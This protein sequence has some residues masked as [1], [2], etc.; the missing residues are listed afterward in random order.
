MTKKQLIIRTAIELFSEKGVESTSVQQITDKSGIS[1]G[2]FY[3]IF[4]S[5]EELILAIID[6]F[7]VDF[8]TKVDQAVRAKHSPDDKL[9]S[10]YLTSIQFFN[11]HKAMALIFLRE[12]L[13]TIGEEALKK[14]FYYDTLGTEFLARFLD[15][16]Y[17]EKVKHTK[18]DLI[19][20][21]NSMLTGYMNKLIFTTH[22]INFEQLAHML[23][24]KTN[25]LAE[26]STLY[27]LDEYTQVINPSTIITTDTLLSELQALELEVTTSIE[28]Q[29]IKLLREEITKETP[30]LALLF[31]VAQ[32]LVS[33][34]HSKW[35]GKL[36]EQFYTY[37][38]KKAE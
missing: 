25:L 18:Y 33:T 27:L 6:H 3:L 32:N 8:N 13:S 17:G 24:E 4:K 34:A 26:H 2:A 38:P 36:I 7:M 11:D 20:I 23:V 30:N 28:L 31:G 14:L 10:Y 19:V 1:K 9:F 21:M 22:D 29:S 12:Q 35:V 37:T 5:K 16:I 15:E